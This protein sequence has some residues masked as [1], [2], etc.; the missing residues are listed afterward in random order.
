MD[1][2]AWTYEWTP[3]TALEDDEEAITR[4]WPSATTQYVLEVEG[5]NGCI[6]KDTMLVYVTKVPESEGTSSLDFVVN[7]GQLIDTEGAPR[8]DIGIYSHHAS[9]MVYCADN[10]LSFV[11]AR[12]DTVAATPDT[13]ARVDILFEDTYREASPIG[14]GLNPHHYNYYLAH[15]PEGVTLTPSYNR[16]VYPQ[17][18]ENTDLHV[19]GN[20]AW[21]KFEFV[22]H[23]GGDPEDIL[24]TFEGAEDVILV[25]QLGLLI[26]TS[27]IGTYV[28]TKP[29][30]FKIDVEGDITELSWQPDWELSVEGN[31]VRFI[32]IGEYDE[33]EV[34]VFRLAEEPLNLAAG[35]GD[36]LRWSTYFGHSESDNAS[37]T[38]IDDFDNI[39]VAG[40]TRSSSFP[41]SI[42]SIQ[43]NISGAEDAFVSYFNSHGVMGWST[44]YGGSGQDFATDVAVT[45]IDGYIYL[46]GHTN[47]SNFPLQNGATGS[48]FDGS[49]GVEDGFIVKLRQQGTRLWSTYFGGQ[50]GDRINT[51][52]LDSEDNVYIGGRGSAFGGFPLVNLGGSTLFNSNG[53]CFVAK[54]SGN[55]VLS[56]STFIHTSDDQWDDLY[57]ICTDNNDNLI[58]VGSADYRSES[59]FDFENQGSGYMDDSFNGGNSDA[60]IAKVLA[61]GALYW[62]TYIGGDD[63]DHASAVRTNSNGD[64]F[65]CGGTKSQGTSLPMYDAGGSSY[66]DDV[67]GATGSYD[68]WIAKFSPTGAQQWFT[69]W[70]GELWDIPN[71]M[72]ISPSGDLYVVGEA[73]SADLFVHDH[74][75]T[76]FQE[77]PN[78]NYGMFNS[79]GFI[80]SVNADLEP[81]WITYFGGT[82]NLFGN[83]RDI[84][85]G[86]SISS[87]GGFLVMVGETNSNIVFP[88]NDAGNGAYWQPSLIGGTEGFISVF[89]IGIGLSVEERVTVTDDAFSIYPNP[90]EGNITIALP[91]GLSKRFLIEILSSTGQKVYE[92][93]GGGGTG[94]VQLDLAGRLSSGLYAVRLLCDDGASYSKTLIYL[95]R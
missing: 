44:F 26:V 57:D 21:M 5:E 28:F 90:T 92:T 41:V 93:S 73:M 89:D 71:Q 1:Q 25:E 27:S 29:N 87:D 22:I 62:C 80:F 40:T 83:Q 2:P 42:G 70:G 64:I 20:N 35:G 66:F 23:P 47:S 24:M 75:G 12:I 74:P 15:C 78:N 59:H 52:T 86:V 37:A 10:R 68:A 19:S 84:S 17:L 6:A 11:H 53:K 14:M 46:V 65:V 8:P 77:I 95:E 45:S 58:I 91:A 32:N 56:W 55:D 60:F 61:N 51:V 4:A 3:S 49:L 69:L 31:S 7:N 81:L 9:P 63:F 82:S 76:Y 67:L 54:F 13:L 85:H 94:T 36:N 18:Y 33:E 16:V 48:Y 38:T 88:V 39:I 30:A 79:N 50:S 43:P 34:L 72:D